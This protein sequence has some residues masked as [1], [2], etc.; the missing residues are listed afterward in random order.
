M[1]FRSAAF[2]GLLILSSFSLAHAEECDRNDPAVI[3]PDMKSL[4]P[5]RARVVE[6]G[7]TRRLYFS[8][9][10]ANVG[11]GPLRIQG[12]T[13]ETQ[14]GQKVT[15]AT[16][17]VQ[18]SDGTTCTHD[19]G[20]F[21]FHA[22]HNH[23]HLNDFA[24]YQLRKDDPLT[25]PIVARASKLSFC[26]I[27]IEPLRGFSGSRQVYGNC[28]SQES[29]QGI[30]AGWADVYD[31]FYPEQ[32]IE[33]DVGRDKPVEAGQYFLVNVADPLNFLLEV[34]EDLGDNSG[35]V[36]VNVPGRIATGPIPSPTTIPVPTATPTP[37][38]TRPPRPTRPPIT[39]PPRPTRAPR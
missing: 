11:Q 10:F 33:L 24:E 39:R 34:D 1:G 3:L 14:F 25:G 18:K 5:A 29:E 36:S 27:D 28:L 15:L 13:I 7:G 26:L 17:V 6:R 16:Q 2:I 22:T 32:Y 35:Y 4:P 12:K 21:E 38:T 23:W 31:D 9:R 37:G 30:S 8:S 20:T 19:A